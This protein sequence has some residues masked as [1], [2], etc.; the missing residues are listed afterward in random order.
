MVYIVYITLIYHDCCCCVK[1][2]FVLYLAYNNRYNVIK[3]ILIGRTSLICSLLILH[4]LK[5]NAFKVL[6]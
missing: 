5:Y 2:N 4:C 1:V 6:F 3:L